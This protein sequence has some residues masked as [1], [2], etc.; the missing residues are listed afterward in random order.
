M[1]IIFNDNIYFT[2]NLYLTTINMNDNSILRLTNTSITGDV[3]VNNINIMGTLSVNSLNS[4][5]NLI[6]ISTRILPTNLYNT[7]NSTN[8][9]NYTQSYQ[10]PNVT[11]LQTSTTTPYTTTNI[12]LPNGI[13]IFSYSYGIIQVSA[14]THWVNI[15]EEYI[16]NKIGSTSTII[17]KNTHYARLAFGVGF[18]Y[19]ANNNAWC[20]LTDTVNTIS[21]NFKL[22]HIGEGITSINIDQIIFVVTRIA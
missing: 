6:N 9:I 5:T 8:Y 2:K 13:Y 19:R 14:T 11:S 16:Y 21:L 4:S 3:S 18:R 15:L 1:S 7:I 12:I 10:L 20:V 22:V 17:V